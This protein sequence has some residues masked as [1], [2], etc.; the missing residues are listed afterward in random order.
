MNVSMSCARILAAFES[1]LHEVE[2]SDKQT[3]GILQTW[4]G[5]KYGSLTD[6]WR[7]YFPEVNRNNL[8]AALR[9]LKV[10]TV[11]PTGQQ[12]TLLRNASIISVR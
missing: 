2:C 11:V 4:K 8:T 12:A 6:L 3:I 5:E 9:R 10:D 1:A 7:N